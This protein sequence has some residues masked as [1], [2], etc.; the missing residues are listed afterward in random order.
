M[1][2]VFSIET[3]AALLVSLSTTILG[4]GAWV[5]GCVGAWVCVCVDSQTPGRL[6]LDPS[7]YL[8]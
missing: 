6:G 8:N 4:V 5:V 3:N 1:A 7:N 2:V